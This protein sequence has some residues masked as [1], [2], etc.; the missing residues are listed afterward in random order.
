MGTKLKDLVVKKE[1]SFQDLQAKR[2]VVDSYNILYQFLTSIRQRDGALLQDGQ[3]RVT[4]HL[5]GLFQ[6]TAKL[7]EY[8]IMPAFVF[9]GKPPALKQQERERRAALKVEAAKKYEKAKEREDLAEMKKYAARTTILTREM[10]TEAKEL[11]EAMGLP[12]IEA[13]SEGEAQA[14]HI[15]NSGDAFAEVSQDYDCLLFGVKRVVRNL[16]ISERK[17][18][19]KATFEMVKPEIIHLQDTLAS[20]G[21]SQDQLIVLGILVGTDFNV[22]GVPGIGPKKAL[23][24]VKEHPTKDGFDRLFT[25][26]R[27]NDYFSFPWQDVFDTIKNIPTTDDYVL[28]WKKVDEQKIKDIL[29]TQHDFSEERVQNT[30]DSLQKEKQKRTQTGL[31][32]WS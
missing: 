19:G 27:W 15:V 23:K 18:F 26:L 17:K 29:C 28:T 7:L 25:E 6:R 9:D 5:A 4:S 14:A 20:L 11:I 12:I 2:I 16:T 3:G 8:S 13:P 31:G 10:I 32:Q 24:L 22:G 30:L 21:V 1:I